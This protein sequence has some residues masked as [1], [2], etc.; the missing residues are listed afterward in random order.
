MNPSELFKDKYLN[1]KEAEALTEIKY[2]A[3]GTRSKITHKD[4][5]EELW[6][7]FE[8]ETRE[9][10]MNLGAKVVNNNN[11]TF[12]LSAYDLPTKKSRQIDAIGYIEHADKK[13]LL[14]IE[15]KH[16][17]RG[18]SGN[19]ALKGAYDEI[20]K[21]ISPVK[22][23]I[24]EI[25]KDG[26]EIIPLWILSSHGHKTSESLQTK[27]LNKGDIIHLAEE[28][29][30]YFNECYDLS[31]SPYF[32]FNQFLGSFKSKSKLFS[33]GEN[34]L[35]S[36]K[37]GGLK[38]IT[39]FHN[40]K[41]AY[42]FTAKVHELMPL[43]MVSHRRQKKIFSDDV[44][45]KDRKG[46]YQRI[47][48]KKRISSVGAHLTNTKKPFTNNIL[49]SFRGKKNNFSFTP[50]KSVGQGRTGELKIQGNPGSF[51]VIDG[52]HRLFGYS[53]I[54]DP[55]ILDHEIIVTAFNDLDQSEEARIFLDVN[56]GQTKVDI[57][58]RREVQMIL[59]SSARGQEQIDNLITSLI[60][61]LREDEDSP[62]NDPVCI[63][64][65]EGRN[66]LDFK[67]LSDA[68]NFGSLLS[69][70]KDF[71]KGYLN[72]KDDYDETLEFATGF[73]K[74]YFQSI[75]DSIPDYWKKRDRENNVVAL[76]TAFIGGCIY[77]LERMITEKTKG[78]DIK[79]KKLF[80]EIEPMLDHLCTKLSNM[81][82]EQKN[83]IFGWR[84]NGAALTEGG[85]KY[86]L[87]R[88]YLI[89]E[90]MLDKYPRLLFEGDL[91]EEVN[92]S[93]G[94]TQ[95]QIA[96]ILVNLQ[97]D[98]EIPQKA[99]EYEIFFWKHL[100]TLLTTIFGADYWTDLI[101]T[102]FS[103]EVFLIA[104]AK[105]QQKKQSK[106]INLEKERL[107]ALYTN[108][109]DWCDWT[110]IKELLTGIYQNKNGEIDTFVRITSDV[111]DLKKLIDE[112]FFIKM[113]SHSQIPQ[114]PKV[115]L[116]WIDFVSEL[117][118]IVAHPREG[119]KPTNSQISQ[120]ESIESNIGQVIDRMK[121]FSDQYLSEEESD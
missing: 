18:G 101:A 44:E 82:N 69:K 55:K 19:A 98:T 57:S 116:E 117:S 33:F 91:K 87:A 47:I 35:D 89:K 105:K 88:F 2:S 46:N 45:I 13:F 11:F 67:R 90:L 86:P 38:I 3:R 104:N 20:K 61:N 58:L 25:F 43:C 92:D 26:K 119:M 78:R 74:K 6:S 118:N 64:L 68:F 60:I 24:R 70:E 31:K 112:I 15:C 1:S 30:L 42:T 97:K 48:T 49:V 103:K 102:E 93:P 81:N 63:P 23:R 29:Q 99:Q 50:H 17:S 14:I 62:F 71:T 94:G 21:N 8:I 106:F 75:R 32:V 9:L 10:L 114:S 22:R 37:V 108:D 72:I 107:E 84:K 115:G 36:L 56:N 28:E 110:E 7:E 111:I 113:P 120:F 95:A 4:K 52:Q 12:D 54:T 96:S 53:K 16:S 79:H 66:A 59:G 80:G 51:H 5:K 85:N 73:I 77:L 121:D 40:K 76:K 83:I 65:P 39:D 109:L 100:H 27:F 41:E 34:K